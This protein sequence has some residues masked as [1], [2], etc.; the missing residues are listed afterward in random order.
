MKETILISIALLFVGV[1]TVYSVAKDLKMKAQ[2][3]SIQK[4]ILSEQILA[5]QR[6]K[7]MHDTLKESADTYRC[8]NDALEGGSGQAR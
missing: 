7:E 6:M 2:E 8:I 3:V 5:N 1:G 4:E